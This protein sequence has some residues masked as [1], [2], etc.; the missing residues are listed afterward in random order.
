MKLKQ[1]HDFIRCGKKMQKDVDAVL[2]L[3]RSRTCLNRWAA[4]FA[5]SPHAKKHLAET[6]QLIAD[7]DAWMKRDK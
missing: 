7:I 1:L 4:R 3:E 6:N 2:L 5:S